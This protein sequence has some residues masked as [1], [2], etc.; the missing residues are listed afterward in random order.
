M[1]VTV[2]ASTFSELYITS[3]PI[4]FSGSN[5]YLGRTSAEWTIKGLMSA[6]DYL[7]LIS[8]YD[9]WRS[10]R[11]ND[12]DPSI[13]GVV[14]TTIFFSGDGPGGYSWGTQCWFNTAPSAEHVGKWLSVS[15]SLTDAAQALEVILKEKEAEQTQSQELI[16]DLG[17]TTIGSTVLTLRKPEYTFGQGPE[18]Q[19]TASGYHYISGPLVASVVRDIEGET[20]LTGWNNI[21][22]W[23]TAQIPTTPTSG[24]YFPTSAP[25]ATAERRL[26]DGV[27]TDVYIVSI[28]LIQIL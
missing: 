23:Y 10:A 18:V 22:S 4:G 5:V 7:D 3:Q 9:E 17:T 1:A 24:D 11:I 26:V 15:F 20:D 6:S 21:R 16:P 28:Q 12:E 8:E 13:S 2:G 19:F 14:G 27:P 25:T